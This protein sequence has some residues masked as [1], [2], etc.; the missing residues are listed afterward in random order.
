MIGICS[1][2]FVMAAGQV[3]VLDKKSSILELDV[4]P[5]TATYQGF[6]N[7]FEHQL[8]STLVGKPH[9]IAPDMTGPSQMNAAFWSRY[10]QDT[11]HY[12][13]GN[14]GSTSTATASGFHTEFLYR[15]ERQLQ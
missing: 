2:K 6:E 12:H 11:R 9:N 15:K 4:G 14:S 1:E 10:D 3:D 7:W 8:D 13:S 5:V